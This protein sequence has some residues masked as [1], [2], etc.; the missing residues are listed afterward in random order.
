VILIIDQSR[1]I[2]ISC[3]WLSIKHNNK[4]ITYIALV[5]VVNWWWYWQWGHFV[6]NQ[7][8]LRRSWQ[9]IA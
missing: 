6:T 3:V 4:L 5:L 2:R 8:Y 9:L 1:N 7:L